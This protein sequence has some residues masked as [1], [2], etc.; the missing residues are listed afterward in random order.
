[1]GGGGQDTQST[2]NAEYPPEFR[3][4]ATG[5]VNQILASQ[6]YNP[7]AQYTAANPSGVAN[8]SPIQR[9]TAQA[10]PL[11]FQN[12]WGLQQMQ[13]MTQPYNTVS[14]NAASIANSGNATYANALNALTSGGFGGGKQS[15]PGPVQP[16]NYTMQ[17]AVA[18]G[19][20]ANETVLGPNT[21]GLVN[22]MM[23]QINIPTNAAFASTVP[24]ISGG[25]P[26]Q[27]AITY[28]N[29]LQNQG[30]VPNPYAGAPAPAPSGM[31]SGQYI[32]NVYNQSA[33]T[34]AAAQPQPVWS[35]SG[36]PLFGPQG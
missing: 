14:R 24:D 6:A 29:S 32:N 2:A 20:P 36:I 18:N 15:F 5:A 25:P 12:S 28:I 17:A 23:G 13:N 33:A 1:M 21:A 19:A 22:N 9:M 3:P 8:L 27:D 34:T 4:L 10:M 11:A 30:Y 7:L 35:L 31:T 26:S 16:P